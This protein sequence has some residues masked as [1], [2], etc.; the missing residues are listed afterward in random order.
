LLQYSHSCEGTHPTHVQHENLCL[1]PTPNTE[2]AGVDKVF[3][4]DD[5]DVPI[6]CVMQSLGAIGPAGSFEGLR[7]KQSWR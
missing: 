7:I 4:E 3:T 6:F 5:D 2:V 1:R